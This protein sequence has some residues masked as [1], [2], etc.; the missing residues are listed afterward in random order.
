MSVISYQLSVISYQLSV[1]GCR[2]SVVGCQA[3]RRGVIIYPVAEVLEARFSKPGGEG[4]LPQ[5]FA[6]QRRV[7]F[8]FKGAEKYE[9]NYDQNS[10]E[11]SGRQISFSRRYI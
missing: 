1:V 9:T 10:A 6:D 2:L 7:D 8:A 5:I 4:G 11:L 3:G